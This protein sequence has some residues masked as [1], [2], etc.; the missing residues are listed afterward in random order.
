MPSVSADDVMLVPMTRPSG[1]YLAIGSVLTES[2]TSKLTTAG[3]SYIVKSLHSKPEN[4]VK[5]V[6]L[7]KSPNLVGAIVKFTGNDY[8]RMAGDTYVGLADQMIEAVSKV[9]HLLLVHESVAGLA[10]VVEAESSEPGDDDYDEGTWNDK[11]AR[12]YFGDIP[13]AVRSKVHAVLDRHGVVLTTYKRNAEASVLSAAF[14]DDVESNL[15]F[16]LY[17]PTGRIYED[18]LAKLLSMFHEWLTNVKAQNIRQS[19]YRTSQGR[20]IEFH[21]NGPSAADG[22][23]SDFEEF[24]RFI[25]LVDDPS[26]AKHM[27]AA[28]GI[29]E[30]KA[31]EIVTRYARDTRRVMLDTKQQRERAILA[32][33]QQLESELSEEAPRVP[34]VDIDALIQ[35]LVPQGPFKTAPPFSAA[36]TGQILPPQ[37]TVIVNQQ[38]IH[39]VEGIVAQSISGA[40]NVGTPLHEIAELIQQHGGELAAAL[41]TDARE[42]ADTGA[43]TATRI[44]ARQRIKTFLIRNGARI[45]AA[46]FQAAW[47]WAESQIGGDA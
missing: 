42:L 12:E 16:R 43:P 46:A 24:S 9:P 4:W 27:L 23:K 6:G 7:L 31:D 38:F 10:T 1:F 18:E 35:K 45:E 30:S 5:I 3:A 44:G 33:Q 2:S 11:R 32:V 21:G 39:R 40:V 15:L 13:G 20:V 25:S 34:A 37:P 29:E 14:I 22:W 17:V 47:K 28:L 26:A 19:G 36:A 41:E 8:E